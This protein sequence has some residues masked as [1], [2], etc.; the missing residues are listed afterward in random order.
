MILLSFLTKLTKSYLEANS[1]K[2][3]LDVISKVCRE[4]PSVKETV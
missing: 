1:T 2:V 3:A 4:F